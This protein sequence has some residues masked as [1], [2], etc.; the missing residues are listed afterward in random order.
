MNAFINT[1]VIVEENGVLVFQGLNSASKG[2]WQCNGGWLFAPQ[3]TGQFTITR[4][5][6][7]RIAFS[8]TVTGFAGPVTFTLN[9]NGAPIPGTTMGQTTTAATDLGNIATEAEI[10]VPVGG[11][12]FITLENAT[13]GAVTVNNASLVISRI[14]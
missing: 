7:Y 14:G 5:G 6:V 2:C 13:A 4:P 12:G 1:P 8:A 11:A 10:R 3:A 9:Q